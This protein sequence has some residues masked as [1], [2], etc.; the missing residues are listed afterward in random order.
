M[1]PLVKNK[2]V[3]VTGASGGIGQFIAIHVAMN[4]GTPILIARSSDKLKVIASILEEK[5]HVSCYWYQADLSKEEEWKAVSDRIINEHNRIDALVNNAGLGVFDY[6]ADSKWEDIDRMIQVNFTALL[7]ATYQVVP[8]MIAH[9]NGH[10]VNIASQ[11]GKMATPKSAVY[12]ATKHAVL[13][14]TN[15]LRME[16][17]HHGVRVTGV[18]LGPVRTNFF[19]QADPSGDY[20]RAVEPWMLDANQVASRIV[21]QLFKEKREINLPAWMEAGSK[22]H[23]QFPGLTEKVLHKQFNKK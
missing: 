10:I 18:N 11:S 23:Y 5:F 20:Q 1:N 22:L 6:F 8:H 9:G 17:A 7:R 4:G 12:A 3:L 16:V 15:A 14:F 2:K 13:G 21:N 19:A